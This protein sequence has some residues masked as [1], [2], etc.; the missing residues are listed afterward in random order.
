MMHGPCGE[1]NPNARCMENGRCTKR[2]PKNFVDETHTQNSGYPEYRRRNDGR[3]I[4]KNRVQLDNRWVVPH[5][6]FLCTKYNAHINVEVCTTIA[7]VKYLYK[8]V[9]KG[10]DRARMYLEQNND[11]SS[12]NNRPA[13][14]VD[15]IRMFLDAR[16]MINSISYKSSI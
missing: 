14:Q 9:Y 4:I 5:N 10:H 6:I 2:F 7:V 1:H 15:E 11:P 12:S 13:V 8:Y 3:S 16:Y